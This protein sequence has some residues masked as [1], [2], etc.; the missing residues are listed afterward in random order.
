MNTHEIIIDR[1]VLNALK[2][3][4]IKKGTQLDRIEAYLEILLQDAK[5]E[6]IEK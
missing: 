1:T 3:V 2:K 4:T 6:V 5:I